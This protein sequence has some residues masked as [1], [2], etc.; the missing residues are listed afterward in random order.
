MPRERSLPGPH[1]SNEDGIAQ[2]EA[3]HLV[4]V[5]T[6]ARGNRHLPRPRLCDVNGIAKCEPVDAVEIA[7]K[8]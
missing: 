6:E 4:E 1:L 3:I 8:V 5:T 2:C 7:R